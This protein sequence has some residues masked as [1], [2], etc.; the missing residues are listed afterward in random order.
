MWGGDDPDPRKPL[1]W[2][3]RQFE[4]ET[5]NIQAGE[6]EKDSVSFNQQ[7]FDLYKKLIA[8]RKSHPVLM[9]GGMDFFLT[10]GQRLG[11]RRFDE[12]SEVLVFFNLEGSAC[13][14]QL[15]ES[16]SYTDLLSGEKVVGAT[17]KIASLD[18]VVLRKD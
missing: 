13:T 17:I 3:G 18:A 8:I 1:W 12:D 15:P 5:A 10:A 14:F 2:K 16:G 9:H 4:Q 11:Y 6:T 7:Q